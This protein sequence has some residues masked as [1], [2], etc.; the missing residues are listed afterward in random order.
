MDKE[1]AR[2]EAAEYAPQGQE[3]APPGNEYADPGPEQQAERA[4]AAHYTAPRQDKHRNEREK[5]LRTLMLSTAAV[6]TAVAVVGAPET[7]QAIFGQW[8]VTGMSHKVELDGS[9][10]LT[11]STHFDRMDDPDYGA[12]CLSWGGGPPQSTAEL[13][14]RIVS[15]IEWHEE[16]GDKRNFYNEE[17]NTMVMYRTTELTWYELGEPNQTINLHTA[18]ENEEWECRIYIDPALLERGAT[19]VARID[20]PRGEDY[21]RD[22]YQY[23]LA[24]GEFKQTVD[25]AWEMN[26]SEAVLQKMLAEDSKSETENK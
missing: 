25:G 14:E 21:Y 6:A 13:R 3:Y 2:R 5:L 20:Y 17:K 26:F 15:D 7:E 19:V 16:R 12:G 10:L 9:V 8:V 18:K 4:P 23:N 11:T 1:K 22:E 24:T